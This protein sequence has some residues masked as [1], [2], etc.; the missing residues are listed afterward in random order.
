MKLPSVTRY[1]LRIALALICLLGAH[2]NGHGSQEIQA[3]VTRE[4]VEDKGWPKGVVEFANLPSRFRWVHCVGFD[5][6]SYRF[7]Y[8]GD[9]EAFKE[10]LKQ[11][12]EIRAPRLELFV[13]DAPRKVSWGEE[14]D[15]TPVDWAFHPT[16][17]R[18]H[19][20]SSNNPARYDFAL[21][22]P[23]KPVPPPR[24]YVYA[25]KGRIDWDK[26]TV[27]PGIHV[28]D[29]R[30]ASK[31]KTPVEGGR[32]T[33]SVWDM[34]T[35]KPVLG[36]VVCMAPRRASEETEAIAPCTVDEDGAFQFD[37]IPKGRYSIHIEAEGYAPRDAGNYGGQFDWEKIVYLAPAVTVSGIVIDTEG[38][39]VAGARV[40]AEDPYGF[41][42]EPYP[43]VNK[44]KPVETDE[45]GRFKFIG[46]PE[47]YIHLAVDQ[48]S[49]WYSLSDEL[50][51]APA[52]D[53]RLMAARTGT[54]RGKVVD[55]QGNP[56][57]S[58]EV[59]FRP[60][61][62]R[63]NKSSPVARSGEDGVFEQ[64]GIVPGEYVVTAE[65]LDGRSYSSKAQY[66]LLKP[67]QTVE[68]Y[69]ELPPPSEDARET[70]R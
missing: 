3:Y 61:G 40:R 37:G 66:V 47:G 49:G 26:V 9:T 8:Q 46:L 11:F 53:V 29:E 45:N 23:P 1:P 30:A 57:G 70:A 19:H 20:R 13:C 65:P 33:G 24:L 64:S 35:G 2:V 54:I 31:P 43:L 38:K 41:D 25:S 12:A 6:E 48:R 51:P 68:V 59:L 52:G 28:Y 63:I 62:D 42:A 44:L 36:A 50:W 18:S 60:R 39:P 10:V 22:S 32:L 7:E 5:W 21:P 16:S 27:P 55:Y 17:P 34:G 15:T 67:G 14:G 56:A 69:L 4:P 58:V